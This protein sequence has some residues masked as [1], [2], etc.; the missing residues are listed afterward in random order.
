MYVGWQKVTK[1]TQNWLCKREKL[2]NSEKQT[3]KCKFR[4]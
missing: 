4:S 3:Q 2:Q 1:V